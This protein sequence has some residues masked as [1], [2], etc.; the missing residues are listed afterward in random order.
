MDRVLENDLAATS[1]D[2]KK[3]I[4]ILTPDIYGVIRNGGIGSAYGHL[5]RFLAAE[6]HNVT[7]AFVNNRARDAE[8]LAAGEA[9]YGPFGVR[10]VGIAPKP[11]SRTPLA[12]V[13]APTIAALSWLREVPE[14][15][16]VHVTEWH[17]LGY[18]PQL[19]KRLGIAFANT[20]F[21]VKGSSPTLWSAQGNHQF[22]RRE[23]DLA[24]VFMERRSVEMADT[25]IAGSRHLIDWMA[26]EGYALPERSFQWPNVFPT[27]PRG[28]AARPAPVAREWVFFGRI[29]P[30]KG[31]LL[32]SDAVDELARRGRLPER[33][34]LLGG[35]STRFDADAVVSHGR[36]RWGIDVVHIADRDAEGAIAYLCGAGRLAVI[37]SLLE[38]ASIAVSECLRAGVPFLACDTGGTGELMRSEDRERL[39]FPPDHHAFADL[40]DASLDRMPA[41]A[42]E[43]VPPDHALDV[44]RR[45]HAQDHD[46]PVPEA[47]ETPG[48][49]VSICLVHHERPHLL[50]QALDSIRAQDHTGIEVILADDGSRSPEAVA[51]LDALEPEFAERGWTILRLPNRYVGAARN[52]A[53]KAATG[54]WLLFFDDDNVM[55]PAMV[56]KMVV[57]ATNADLDLLTSASR[58]FRGDGD[59]RSGEDATLGTPITFCGP[60]PS[61]MAT[62]NVLGDACC[63]VRREVHERI[64]GYRERFR[65]GL[66]DLEYYNRLIAAGARMESYPD[67]LYFY[68]EAQAQSMKGKNRSL[69]EAQFDAILGLSRTV[70]VGLRPLLLFRPP[71]P[72]TAKIE[73]LRR[74]GRQGIKRRFAASAIGRTWRRLRSGVARSSGN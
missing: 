15:D 33:I 68:R 71:A 54:D 49:K 7:I 1:Q 64:G 24:W 10:F 62:R 59:P 14:F 45:W 23:M 32:F 42:R 56:R 40:L 36:K 53:A 61:W 37:P 29:E 48:T 35:P 9:E 27:D 70:P 2:R 25:F 4:C 47:G 55:M 17:A 12:R 26:H 72:A 66:D 5:A 52:S 74:Q 31:I 69:E 58:R 41:P 39:L 18:L 11:A 63:L 50:A 34:T 13:M 67:P 21:V 19:A 51:A 73:S 28:R 43:A 65:V 46:V 22:L 16:L 20:H 3:R 38:N 44:W 6:G 60:D 30:R 57:A 8:A